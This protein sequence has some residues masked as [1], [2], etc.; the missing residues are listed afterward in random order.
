[1]NPKKLMALFAL[2]MVVILANGQKFIYRIAIPASRTLEAAT[3][4]IAIEEG[5]I[6]RKTNWCSKSRPA[7]KTNWKQPDSYH[8]TH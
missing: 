7:R 8:H 1:M 3:L 5:Y 2:T 6:N 4:G